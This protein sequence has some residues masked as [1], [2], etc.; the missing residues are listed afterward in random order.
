MNEGRKQQNNK[1]MSLVE[2]IVVVLIL[3]IISVGSIIGFTF[4]RS[5]DASSAGKTMLSL[6]NR[7]KL[8]TTA[9]KGD[10]QVILR[11]VLEDDN[12]YGKLLKK[13]G[14]VETELDKVEIGSKVIKISA[15]IDDSTEPLVIDGTKTCDITYQKSN[16]AF[17]SS[18]KK[19]EIEGSEK[20]TL[21]MVIDTGRCYLE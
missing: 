16:G 13:D 20:K 1:G 19:F 6:L 12:Y 5:M 15:K 4:I 3:G 2:L 11:I 8:E 21:Y 18:Y 14:D 9:T 7:A 17:T 10:E